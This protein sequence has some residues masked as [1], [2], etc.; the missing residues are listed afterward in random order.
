[1]MSFEAQEKREAYGTRSI[2]DRTKCTKKKVEA[3]SETHS[4]R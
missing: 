2:D 3:K 1:M 4:G